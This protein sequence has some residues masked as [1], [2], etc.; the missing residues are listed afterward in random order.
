MALSLEDVITWYNRASDANT[1]VTY[2]DNMAQASAAEQQVIE[3]CQA[4]AQDPSA[5]NRARV[6]DAVNDW[7]DHLTD[8]LSLPYPGAGSPSDLL[9]ALRNVYSPSPLGDEIASA[10]DR[11]NESHNLPTPEG[12]ILGLP[13]RRM[14][15]AFDDSFDRASNHQLLVDP[16]ILDLDGDGIETLSSNGK[17][18]FDNNSDGIATGIGWVGRDDGFL[19]LDRNGNGQI[20]SGRELFGND[21]QLASGEYATD[22]FAALNELDSNSDGIINSNDVAFTSLQ[23]WRDI[24]SN[25]SSRSDELFSLTDLGITSISLAKT[26]DAYALGNGNSVSGTSSFIWADGRTG[27]VAN[28]VLDENTVYSA[29]LDAVQVSAEASALPNVHGMGLVRDLNQAATLSNA[30]LQTLTDYAHATSG[31]AQLLLIPDLITQWADT[32]PNPSV[33]TVNYEFHGGI[34]HYI[35]NDANAGVTAEY[36]AMLAKVLVIETFEGRALAAQGA[37]TVWVQISLINAAYDTLTGLVHD[38]LLPQT[39]LKPYFD[40]L[41]AIYTDTTIGIDLSGFKQLIAQNMALNSLEAFRDLVDMYR[42]RG[43]QLMNYGFNMTE[44]LANYIA[45]YG[46]TSEVAA[47]FEDGGVLAGSGVNDNLTSTLTHPTVLGLGGNDTISS[48]NGNNTLDGGAGDDII[49]DRGAGSNTLRGGAGNDTITYSYWSNNTIEGGAGND[50]IKADYSQYGSAPYANTFIGGTGNDLIQSGG[51]A[52]TYLFNRGDGQDTI[53]DYGNG[54]APG[55]DKL[56]FGAGIAKSDVVL[57]RSG[58]HLV[59]KVTDPANPL[60][61][62]QITIENWNT[63]IYR[64]ES[65]LFANGTEWTAQDLTNLSMTGS[66]SAETLALWSDATWAS[67]LGGNDN[68]NS[69]NNDAT[70]YGGDGNDTITDSSGNDILDGG[71]GDDIITDRGSSTNTNTL[72]GGAGNDTIT[73]SYW[74]NNTIEGG[75]GNDLIK[76]DYSQYGSAPYANTFIGGTGND[77]IQSGGS[78]DTYLFN[79]GDGQDT[80]NDYGNGTAP[81]TDKLVFGAGI[82][83]SDI[84]FSRSGNNLLVSSHGTTDSVAVESWYSSSAY[85]IEEIVLTDGTKL[86]NTQ[87]DLLIQAMAQF[88]STA[89]L[90]WDQALDQQPQEV[91]AVLAAYWQPIA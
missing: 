51:S 30:L 90:T 61:T 12:P 27:T 31:A 91:E 16:L 52:D 26:N 58:E 46:M 20:D 13:E 38:A 54:T 62:D 48:D 85:Q 22:G 66:E 49:T 42:L 18:L 2:I 10:L 79:R 83:K 57:S 74:S 69:G 80:I 33:G 88:S 11:F 68:I 44:S 14:C 29:Y 9:G 89:G 50:L 1:V 60:A 86:L 87:V 63:A 32:A 70:V 47:L 59:I 35:N 71:A 75:A 6:N 56:V 72:R 15:R 43:T 76:A 34:Q 37:T 21:T 40:A 82:A 28:A 65:V 41:T 53:N 45:I 39:R 17:I 55:T 19:V 84:I 4:Y 24:D 8:S 25:G 78:A 77:L 7:G 67:G 73:Y 3:A 23:V 5:E 81:G 36:A 64:I